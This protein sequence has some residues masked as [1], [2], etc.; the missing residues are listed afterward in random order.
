MK[1]GGER[2]SGMEEERR[3]AVRV[4]ESSEQVHR[5]AGCARGACAHA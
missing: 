1:T 3:G 4:F 2:L 5:A